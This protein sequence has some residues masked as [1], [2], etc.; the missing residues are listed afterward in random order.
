MPSAEPTSSVVHTDSSSCSSAAKTQSRLYSSGWTTW[1]SG[2]YRW[3]TGPNNC[4]IW[5][6]THISQQKKIPQR[7][8]TGSFWCKLQQSRH[9]C[10][11]ARCYAWLLHPAGKWLEAA[12]WEASCPSWRSQWLSLQDVAPHAFHPPTMFILLIEFLRTNTVVSWNWKET[13]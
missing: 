10:Q 8:L 11:V 5:G 6:W 2:Y 13:A 7:Q 1:C 9:S 4:T 3:D 12:V